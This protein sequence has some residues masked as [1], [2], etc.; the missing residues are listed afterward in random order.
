MSLFSESGLTNFMIE[1]SG[2][3]EFGSDKSKC[4]D[5]FDV[6]KECKKKEVLVTSPPV[7]GF[8]CFQLICLPFSL[9]F[10]V[11]SLRGKL[12]WNAIKHGPCSRECLVWELVL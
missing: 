11:L 2:L 12:D 4:Q 1:L 7:F 9:W 10:H 6:Y 5:H 8:L 3:E